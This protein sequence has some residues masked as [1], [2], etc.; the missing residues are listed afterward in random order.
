MAHQPSTN[1][2]QQTTTLAILAG[3]KATRLDGTNKALIEIDGATIIQKV[4]KTLSSFCN[5]I[6]IISNQPQT[7]YGIPAKV[8]PDIIPDCG[9][10]SGIHSALH[11]ASN[12]AVLI[13]PSDMPFIGYGIV[14]QLIDEYMLNQPNADI[15]VPTINGFIEPLLGIYKKDLENIAFKI[16][17]NKKG[18]SVNELVKTNNAIF[19]EI[20]ATLENINSFI[21][22]NTPPD[23]AKAKG[24]L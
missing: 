3:G 6:I 11:H 16:L 19:V 7:N 14:K 21:N 13:A 24:L 12:N 22:I 18:Y 5:E 1:N 8:Y 2:K 10:L 23:I 20:D 17:Q 15:A 9:P 4:Y